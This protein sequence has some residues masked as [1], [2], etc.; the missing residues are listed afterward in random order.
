MIWVLSTK[1]QALWCL[2]ILL[3]WNLLTFKSHLAPTHSRCTISHWLREVIRNTVGICWTI[4][5][6]CLL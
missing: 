3:A 4:G 1:H 2:K 5:P 6:S